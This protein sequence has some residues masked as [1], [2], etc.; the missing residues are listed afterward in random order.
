MMNETDLGEEE[1]V[2]YRERTAQRE[3]TEIVEE[4]PAEI[5]TEIQPV[6]VEEKPAVPVVET[7][8]I[9]QEP[10]TATAT[11]V[12]QSE[13]AEV[14]ATTRL[15][16]EERKIGLD[17]FLSGFQII[18]EI[19]RGGICR[20]LRVG[21]ETTGQTYAYKTLNEETVE[22]AMKTN[23]EARIIMTRLMKEEARLMGKMI[24]VMERRNVSCFPNMVIDRTFDQMTG[25]LTEDVP[26]KYEEKLGKLETGEGVKLFLGAA[27]PVQLLHEEDATKCLGDIKP[28]NFKL[29][30]KGNV[31]LVD[32]NLKYADPTSNQSMLQS[33]GFS[34]IG[35]SS[36]LRGTPRY[37][38]P[39]QWGGQAD[40]RTDVFQLGS[41]LYETLTG[42]KP[43]GKWE[44]L[45]HF[46]EDM[47]CLDEVV[48]KAMARKPENR[49]QTVGELVTAVKERVFAS[50]LVEEKPL[51]EGTQRVSAPAEES[52]SPTESALEAVR[53]GRYG[54]D[55][56][57]RI[58]L[59][60]FEKRM[61]ER[62]N[63]DNK[64][65][66]LK[67]NMGYYDSGDL[68]FGGSY[69][70]PAR[71]VSERKG[72]KKVKR[73]WSGR[74]D[75]V[76]NVEQEYLVEFGWHP[77]FEPRD[78]RQVTIH[79][80]KAAALAEKVISELERETDFSKLFTPLSIKYAFRVGE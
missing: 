14:Q 9:V 62:L 40:E 36:K 54:Y 4:K 56:S 73:F 70:E 65:G 69:H 19:G 59:K 6:T 24:S 27:Q 58:Y 46:R 55:E 71:L 52:R 80:R 16:E 29:D 61:K 60:E 10:V 64:K 15:Q 48:D 21:Q 50:G 76:P 11:E 33:V 41:L 13:V 37:M 26:I 44:A 5:A 12:S 75:E 31:K 74:V 53:F 57:A 79:S 67:M 42:I 39:E 30:K 66:E 77:G 34:I 32:M 38:A 1:A 28:S 43:E 45:A 51:V 23:P 18:E 7:S 68:L 2:C 78:I 47:V 63:W 3:T 17:D 35:D 8:Q 22:L 25:V 49:Y 20:V 72:T